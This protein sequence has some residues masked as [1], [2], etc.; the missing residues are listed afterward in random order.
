MYQQ[1]QTNT[2]L[3][4]SLI[5]DF[6]TSIFSI[7]F[8]WSEDIYETMLM[9]IVD[10][11]SLVMTES[12][13]SIFWLTIN[14]TGVLNTFVFAGSCQDSMAWHYLTPASDLSD[15]D[16]HSIKMSWI[17]KLPI[18][19]FLEWFW[20]FST[21]MILQSLQTNLI[22]SSCI[23][24]RYHVCNPCIITVSLSGRILSPHWCRDIQLS[25]IQ[26]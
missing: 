17:S 13:L 15:I 20:W 14:F 19:W 1:M 26:F 2:I 22:N 7:F 8:S 24:D 5:S 25:S 9:M 18:S 4:K 11:S 3:I 6:V 16:I 23:Y 21:L 10:L 12:F